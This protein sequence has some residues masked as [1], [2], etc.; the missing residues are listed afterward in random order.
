[1]YDLKHDA[2]EVKN[3]ASEPAYKVSLIC[4]LY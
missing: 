2:E 4:C 1:L 3:V